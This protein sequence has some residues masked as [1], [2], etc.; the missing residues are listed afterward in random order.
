[1]VV[2]LTPG[3]LTILRLIAQGVGVKGAAQK[4]DRS[5]K[6]IQ[7]HL[8]NMREKLGVHTTVE[9]VLVSLRANVISLAD[10][11]AHD[12]EIEG[13][14]PAAIPECDLRGLAPVPQETR[15]SD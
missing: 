9:L 7:A 3:E 6:T 14:A 2:Q 13:P 8:T 5:P 4:L 15:S 12:A 11:P 1:M 10:L